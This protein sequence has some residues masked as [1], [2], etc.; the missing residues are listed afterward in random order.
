MCLEILSWGLVR[1]S[2]IFKGKIFL[3][4]KTMFC[5]FTQGLALT[6]WI[7][8]SSDD[9]AVLSL[10]VFKFFSHCGQTTRPISNNTW[11]R[12]EV[13]IRIIS[14]A[15]YQAT[16]RWQTWAS[17]SF[18]QASTA[19][20]RRTIFTLPGKQTL[21]VSIADTIFLWVVRH[22]IKFSHLLAS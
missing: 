19:Q 11:F 4:Q 7:F 16:K 17:K 15:H 6:R 10:H 8:C 18:L 20:C 22:W 3:S 12:Y 21:R 14:A 1:C 13:Y 5:T 9:T 2:L